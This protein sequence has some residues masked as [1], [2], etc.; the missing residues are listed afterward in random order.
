MITS[1]ASASE[2]PL[3]G[4]PAHWYTNSGVWLR[5]DDPYA[6]FLPPAVELNADGDSEFIRAVVIVTEET[7]NG[8]ARSP[9]EYVNPLLVLS[10]RDYASISF[11]D[12]VTC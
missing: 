7:Q 11:Y 3:R 12:A 8:T 6:E 4:S 9:E 1:A 10:G 2:L 5:E